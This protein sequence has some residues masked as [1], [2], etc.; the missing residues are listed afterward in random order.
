MKLFV[1]GWGDIYGPETLNV[2]IDSSHSH[3]LAWGGARSGDRTDF[4]A[5]EFNAAEFNAAVHKLN[6]DVQRLN[7]DVD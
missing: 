2:G 7:V 1:E 5:A 3:Q 4:L 6:V